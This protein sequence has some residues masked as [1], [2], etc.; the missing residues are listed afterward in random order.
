[1]NSRITVEVVK[2]PTARRNVSLFLGDTVA[3][4]LV[5]AFGDEDYSKYSIVVNGSEADLR[6]QL[7][8]GDSIVVSKMV[9]G[10]R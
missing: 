8:N 5:E 10:N 9:K 1:M 4:A 7:S 2:L 6:T 3:R